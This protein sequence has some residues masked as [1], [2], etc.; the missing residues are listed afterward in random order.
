M[1]TYYVVML[2]NGWH[3]AGYWL[4]VTLARDVI[5]E[6]KVRPKDVSKVR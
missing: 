4:A 3:V 1:Y 2:N 6:Q 5:Q